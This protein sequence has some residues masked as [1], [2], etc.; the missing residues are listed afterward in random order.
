M[1]RSNLPRSNLEKAIERVIDEEMDIRT[2]LRLAKGKREISSSTA[3]AVPNLIQSSQQPSNVRNRKRQQTLFAF[4]TVRNE[5]GHTKPIA[6]PAFNEEYADGWECSGC[7][8]V[9]E[10]KR[11]LEEHQKVCKDHLAKNMSISTKVADFVLKRDT[12]KREAKN[13]DL[14]EIVQ[15]DESELRNHSTVHKEVDK[16]GTEAITIEEDD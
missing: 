15:S 6:T 9:C 4:V 3:A 13:E 14:T 10:R 11:A 8:K 5:Y 12:D 2:A 1:E 16:S 7:S